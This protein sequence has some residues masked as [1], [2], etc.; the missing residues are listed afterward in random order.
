VSGT[1]ECTECGKFTLGRYHNAVVGWFSACTD[2][3]C[4]ANW[5]DTRERLLEAA[6]TSDDDDFGASLGHGEPCT[7]AESAASLVAV[8]DAE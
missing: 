4:K 2:K 7:K 5:F 8:E 1:T 6:R 3:T